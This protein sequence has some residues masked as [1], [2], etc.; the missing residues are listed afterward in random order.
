[1]SWKGEQAMVFIIGGAYQGKTEYAA[2]YAK[3]REII[4]NYHLRIQEQMKEGKEPLEEAEQLL[5]EKPDCVIVC[6]EVGCGLVPIDSFEREY[7][8]KV[9]RV[10]CL[11][12]GKAEAVIR[13]VCG[14][15][16]QIK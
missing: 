7:R 5:K 2:G 6:D 14:I 1:M 4:N 16:T 3:G 11:F 8:E 15:G 9:G 13:V 12:A 10:G